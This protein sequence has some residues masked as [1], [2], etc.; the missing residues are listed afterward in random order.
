MQS[1]LFHCSGRDVLVSARRF[2]CS[3]LATSDETWDSNLSSLQRRWVFA[4]V[5]QPL[6]EHSFLD[7]SNIVCNGTITNTTPLRFEDFSF[8]QCLHTAIQTCP[9]LDAQLCLDLRRL[10]QFPLLAIVSARLL[11]YYPTFP[12]SIFEVETIASRMPLLSADL[13]KCR[14]M[15]P[16]MSSCF[17]VRNYT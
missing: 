13:L 12:F 4:D 8:R 6:S 17:V 2:V 14:L 15:F 10:P 3:L 5:L 9:F 1:L 7:S 16:G 11:Q